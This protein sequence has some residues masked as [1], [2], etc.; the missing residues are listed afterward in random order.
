MRSDTYD[1]SDMVKN[2]PRRN[3]F[4]RIYTGHRFCGA[5]VVDLSQQI[6]ILCYGCL[7]CR[8]LKVPIAHTGRGAHHKD[9]I[10]PGVVGIL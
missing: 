9:Y 5:E 6:V 3:I 7:S 8:Q 4:R 10:S 1:M 2:G